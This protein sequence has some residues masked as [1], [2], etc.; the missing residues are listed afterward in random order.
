MGAFYSLFVAHQT[1]G[2]NVIHFDLWN[3]SGS[4][5]YLRVHSIE[6]VVSGEVAAVGAVAIALHLKRTTAIGT[7]GTAATYEG[8]DS[9]ASTFSA[10][11]NQHRLNP[12]I[13]A[14]RL[15]TG[16]ATAGS[17]LRHVNV[18]PEETNSGAY[19]VTVNLARPAGFDTPPIKVP[20]GTGISVVQG[21][22]ASLGEVGYNV[23]FEVVPNA[24]S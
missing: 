6:A 15:P 1:A 2:A 21:S 20:E 7:A 22:V 11:D 9:T 18:F 14:R 19:S 24:G 8:T 23:V 3:A 12:L 10:I 17:Q 13:T 16:G 5:A 4:T